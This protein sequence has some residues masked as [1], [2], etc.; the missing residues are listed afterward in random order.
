MM[1]KRITS[2]FISIMIV[3]TSCSPVFAMTPAKDMNVYFIDVGQGDSILIKSENKT[4]LI[5]SG[6]SSA[7]D[8]LIE[9]LKSK[10]V[11]KIDYLVATHPDA[12]H[13][14]SMVE[15]LDNFKVLDSDDWFDEGAYRELIETLED[16][17]VRESKG[18][19]GVCPDLLVCNYTYNHLDEGTKKT[20]R[21]GNVFPENQR[22]FGMEGRNFYQPKQK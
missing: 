9:F 21:Y 12:D 15:V 16:W 19:E 13:I 17:C 1:K 18:E 6:P 10:N 5:D 2:I 14:G 11:K 4:M 8:D 3:F 7:G 22:I 20:M